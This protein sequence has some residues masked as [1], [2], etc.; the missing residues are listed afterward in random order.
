VDSTSGKI[1]WSTFIGPGYVGPVIDDD[2]IYIGTCSHGYNPGVNECIYAVDRFTGEII[3]KK[4]IFYGIPESIQYD[5]D[6]LYFCGDDGIIYALNKIDGSVNWIYD[7][8]MAVCANK[9]MLKD[10]ALYAAYWDP[11]NEGTFFKLNVSDGSIMWSIELSGGPW[12][13]S[14]TA[15]GEG[16]IFL[17][18]YGDRS[19]NAFNELDGKRIWTYDLYGFPLSFNA[20]HEGVVFIA[21]T[22]GYVYA[23]NATNGILIW[24][25]KI[26]DTIDISSPTLSN[27]LLFI[28]TRD[29]SEGAFFALNEITG[30]VLWKCTIGASVTSPPSIV[31][32]MMLCGTD[33]WYLYAFDVGIGS[34]DWLL[35]RY[36]RWNTAYS[37]SGLTTWQY[38]EANCTPYGNMTK[39]TI[40]NYYDHDVTN[41]TLRLGDSAGAYWYDASGTLLKS[42]SDNYTINH[43]S[44]ASS[45]TFIIT[46]EVENLAPEKPCKPDGPNGGR[47]GISCTYTTNA[48]DPDGDQLYYLWDWGDDTTSGWLGPSDCGELTEASHIWDEEGTYEVK[49]KARDIYNFESPWSD[50]LIVTLPKNKLVTKQ[51]IFHIVDGVIE[52][53]L[54]FFRLLHLS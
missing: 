31:D 38:V 4:E 54:L 25:N 9:P 6:K 36:D 20:Y 19:M 13:N 23:L 35:H 34:D 33:G 18:I 44:G 15:D 46:F 1:L 40:T 51:A 24:E 17:A 52:R 47:P 28:G 27:G 12:D 14:I 11:G 45:L 8:G 30:D 26:G 2:M 37:P 22:S 5:S 32:G 21:D 10:N 49:V 7:T 29:F 16:R 50:P 39:C 3:W 53:F 41:I 48:T 43:L 42:D